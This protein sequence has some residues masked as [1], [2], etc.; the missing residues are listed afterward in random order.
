MDR[1]WRLAAGGW[2]LVAGGGR[3]GLAGAA[4]VTIKLQQTR[5]GGDR[6]AVTT[7]CIL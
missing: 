2:W 1:G 5:C 3:F 7:L 4:N 6:Y